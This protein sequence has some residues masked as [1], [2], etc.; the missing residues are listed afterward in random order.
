MSTIEIDNGRLEYLERLLRGKVRSGCTGSFE[1]LIQ[2][3]L[4]EAEEYNLRLRVQFAR[5]M[6]RQNADEIKRAGTN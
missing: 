1:H 2:Q 4:N 5:E 6:R 3:V